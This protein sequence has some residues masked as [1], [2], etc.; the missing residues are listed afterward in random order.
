ME[1]IVRATTNPEVTLLKLNELSAPELASSGFWLQQQKDN[2]DIVACIFT[3]DKDFPLCLSYFSIAV[4]KHHDQNNLQKKAF[5]WGLTV[6]EG[7]RAGKKAG[8]YG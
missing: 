4:T 7:S 1:V 5:N 8:R 6:P 2:T 3:S